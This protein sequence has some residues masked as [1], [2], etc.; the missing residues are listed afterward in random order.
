M[1]KYHIGG[2]NVVSE[3]D[4]EIEESDFDNADVSIK[5]ADIEFYKHLGD[6]E[7][8][9][10]FS[11]DDFYMKI[12]DMATF[13]V[14][15]GDTIVVDK[16]PQAGESYYKMF[17][18]GSSWG[19]L[20]HQ[21][22]IL[23][24]H[25]SSVEFEGKGIMICGI[26]GGGKSSLSYNLCNYGAKYLCD[27]ITAVKDGMIQPSHVSIKLWDDTL[28]S[29]GKDSS[30]LQQIR[31]DIDKFYFVPDRKSNKPVAID[32][33]YVLVPDENID[34]ICIVDLSAIEKINC[35]K[36][37]IYRYYFVK[38]QPEILKGYINTIMDIA[39]KA[40]VK[41]VRR[42]VNCEINEL[43]KVVIRDINEI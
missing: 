12:E 39:G 22:E 14:H 7:S 43:T 21:R 25:A 41:L 35:L 16:G 20:L 8:E 11:K 23:P 28:Q 18:K 17:V 10:S 36:H 33:I 3:I 30:S 1:N 15:N 5:E 29:L 32:N 31:E 6:D 4:L 42:P 40:K 27:D 19:A 34:E 9:C 38:D 26:S 37:Q 24:F 13:S 2:L